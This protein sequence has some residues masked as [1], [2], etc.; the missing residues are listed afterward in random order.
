M[1]RF[2][3]GSEYWLPASLPPYVGAIPPHPSVPPSDPS[4]GD[5]L[6][7]TAVTLRKD[8]FAKTAVLHT[9]AEKALTSHTGY[10][11]AIALSAGVVMAWKAVAAEAQ[12]VKDNSSSQGGAYAAALAQIF[13]DEAALEAK[14]GGQI[15]T[16]LENAA[17]HP[18]PPAPTPKPAP[19]DPPVVFPGGP[20][21]PR[22]P[23]FPPPVPPPPADPVGSV[24]L[25]ALG[26]GIAYLGYRVF[27]RKS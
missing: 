12:K 18:L 26:A 16:L 27:V 11:A 17:Q 7:K 2:S 21:G 14:D 9:D 25:L 13:L 22:P 4:N 10:A 6:F 20:G 5:P 8:A 1:W 15:K 3:R 19:H 23:S 24:G